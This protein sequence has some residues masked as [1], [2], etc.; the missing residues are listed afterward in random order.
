MTQLKNQLKKVPQSGC[1]HH[2]KRLWSPQQG[3]KESGNGMFHLELL[4][5]LHQGM[6]KSICVC[7]GSKLGLDGGE[8]QGLS[9]HKDG[10]DNETR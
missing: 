10:K 4:K 3:R 6:E 5:W 7:Q 9:Q 2:L 8:H 1:W